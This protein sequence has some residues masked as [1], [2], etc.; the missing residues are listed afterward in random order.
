M[1]MT[2]LDARGW[3][4]DHKIIVAN[5]VV[6]LWVWLIHAF[7]LFYPHRSPAGLDMGPGEQR[8]SICAFLFFQSIER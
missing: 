6:L 7:L 4:G 1:V 8:V 3:I 5:T 2:I